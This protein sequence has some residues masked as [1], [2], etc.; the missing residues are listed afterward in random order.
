MSPLQWPGSRPGRGLGE[1][2]LA[3]VIPVSIAIHDDATAARVA[4]S[5]S[6]SKGRVRVLEVRRGTVGELWRPPKGLALV[7]ED[8]DAASERLARPAWPVVL[9]GQYPGFKCPLH[10][11][12]SD[13]RTTSTLRRGTTADARQLS[14][15]FRWLARLTA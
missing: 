5:K 14:S 1:L 4:L 7:P 15:R 6:A 13:R 10:C 3:G 9:V 2:A 12:G 8:P 11:C